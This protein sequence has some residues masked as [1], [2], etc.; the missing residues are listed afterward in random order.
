[1]LKLHTLRRRGRARCVKKI[2]DVFRVDGT[3]RALDLGV[4]HCAAARVDFV[5][6]NGAEVR[7][8]H[9]MDDKFKPW[10]RMRKRLEVVQHRERVDFEKMSAFDGGCWMSK[11]GV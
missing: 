4:R 3:R 1:M 8:R 2:G 10:R 6:R 9:H 11:I 5:E 7:A